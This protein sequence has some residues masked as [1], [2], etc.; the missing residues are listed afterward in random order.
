MW[1]SLKNTISKKA[2]AVAM[3][4]NIVPMI[5]KKCLS[6]ADLNC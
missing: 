2:S 3:A 5:L 6:L 4:V 1:C